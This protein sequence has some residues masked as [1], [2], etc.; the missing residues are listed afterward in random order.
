MNKELSIQDRISILQQKYPNGISD[1]SV[2]SEEQ[3]A[4]LQ[5]TIQAISNCK[6]FKLISNLQRIHK[7]L[8][9]SLEDIPD[10]ELLEMASY[11]FSNIDEI[12][13]YKKG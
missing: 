12:K 8:I 5:V 4:W 1:I 11:I 6:E 13:A 3:K 2:L 10:K 7:R 9:H